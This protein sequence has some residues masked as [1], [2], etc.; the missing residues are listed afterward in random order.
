MGDD[1]V[2]AEEIRDGCSDIESFQHGQ[3]RAASGEICGG[4]SLL[5]GGEYGRE[6]Y[7]E[8]TYGY[9]L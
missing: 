5:G 2:T 1:E 4:R 6:I 9:T 8:A 7:R 3:I